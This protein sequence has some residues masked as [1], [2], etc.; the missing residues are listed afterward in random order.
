MRES[1]T[2]EILFYMLTMRTCFN[3]LHSTGDLRLGE[4]LTLFENKK[5]DIFMWK[6]KKYII[7]LL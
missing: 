7:F 6:K 3:S 2:R 5:L 4:D 1:N